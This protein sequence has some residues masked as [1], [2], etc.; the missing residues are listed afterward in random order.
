MGPAG[1]K[2]AVALFDCR[3]DEMIDRGSHSIVIGSVAAVQCN[4][5]GGVL[6]YW[7]GQYRPLA[8]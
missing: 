5:S 6:T 3:L 1:L 4:D 7:R 8:A 2:D